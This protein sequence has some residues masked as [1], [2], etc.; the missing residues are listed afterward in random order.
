[1]YVEG[2]LRT[3]LFEDE[4][5]ALHAQTEVVA[6]RVIL[7]TDISLRADERLHLTRLVSVPDGAAS[8]IELAS[9]RRDPQLALPAPRLRPSR[10]V[11]QQ[12]CPRRATRST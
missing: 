12:S 8:A 4:R 6:G 3:E 9:V 7:L 5:R 10:Q 11:A 2:R 1:M